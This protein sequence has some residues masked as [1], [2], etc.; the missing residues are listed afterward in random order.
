MRAARR[1]GAADLFLRLDGLRVRR[2]QRL[3]HCH[4]YAELSGDVEGRPP[5][6][7]VSHGKGRLNDEMDKSGWGRGAIDRFAAGLR[8]PAPAA[9]RVAAAVGASAVPCAAG[10]SYASPAHPHHRLFRP[11]VSVLATTTPRYWGAR[12]RAKNAARVARG[13]QSERP[14]SSATEGGPTRSPPPCLSRRR[15]AAAGHWGGK[16]TGGGP[17]IAAREGTVAGVPCAAALVRNAAH[18]ILLSGLC[19][20]DQREDL[21]VGPFVR[22]GFEEAWWG[23]KPVHPLAWSIAFG[24]LR[25]GRTRRGTV[26]RTA[27][28]RARSCSSKAPRAE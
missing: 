1:A 13:E 27:R 28:L 15:R 18:L 10:R 22:V 23:K 19:W 7:Y 26:E 25:V 6:L 12:S 20:R 8:S 17:R 16:Q 4:R 2:E 11:P 3:H 14:R 9:A 5:V 24:G 21:G